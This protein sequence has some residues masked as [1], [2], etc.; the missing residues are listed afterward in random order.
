MKKLIFILLAFLA[1]GFVQ[2]QT[3]KPMT[4]TP[5]TNDSVVGAATKYCTLSTPITGQW[6]GSLEVYLTS[7]V[8]ANDSTWVTVEGSMDNSTWYLV[9]LGTPALSGSATLTGALG[10]HYTI[11]AASGGLFFTPTWYLTPPYL[12]IKLQHYVAATSIKITR[13]KLYL[14]R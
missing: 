13:A 4:F 11:G 14:K 6:S 8:G 12:R 5:A 3:G 2:A 7:S 9:D 10:G 1:F